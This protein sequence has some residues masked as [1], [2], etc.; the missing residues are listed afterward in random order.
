[1]EYVNIQHSKIAEYFVKE[2]IERLLLRFCP[3]LNMG[4]RKVGQD[5]H[6]T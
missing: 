5:Q 6:F 2:T 1:M 3:F 4:K